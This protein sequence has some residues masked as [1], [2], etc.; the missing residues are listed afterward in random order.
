MESLVDSSLIVKEVRKALDSQY[1]TN[2]GTVTLA[3]NRTISDLCAELRS[4]GVGSVWVC[5][6]YGEDME[7]EPHGEDRTLI[8]AE[9]QSLEDAAYMIAGM[10]K[11][12]PEGTIIEEKPAK[13]SVP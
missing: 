1:T 2:Q 12:T 13:F 7:P 5:C 8:Y 3:G 10:R 11:I 6:H 9:S 4:Y